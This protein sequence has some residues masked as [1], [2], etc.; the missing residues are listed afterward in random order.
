M[1]PL[2]A[3]GMGML[4]AFIIAEISLRL[5]VDP[6]AKRLAT[7]DATLGWKGRPNGD[8]LYVRKTDDIRVPFH[9]NNLGFRDEDVA[10]KPEHGRRIL[11]LGDSFIENL[12]VEY[13]KTFPFLLE[14][15]VKL[16]SREWDVAIVGSQGYSTAQQ[17][18]AFRSYHDAISPDVVLLCFYC[19]NDFEDN[20]RRRFAFLDEQGELC[21]PENNGSIWKHRARWLQRWLYESSHVVYLLKN[22]FQSLTNVRL[23]P[24]SKS[25]VDADE[26]YKLRI[27]AKL[28]QQ[29]A[30][31]AN[32]AGAEFGIVVIPFRDD[33]TSG[34]VQAQSFV[35]RLCEDRQIP[36]LDLSPVLSTD[37]YFKTDIHFNIKGHQIAAQAINEFLAT[38]FQTHP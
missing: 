21:I 32:A 25:I 33:L 19:G 28:L 11:I 10:A 38:S 4:C 7:Y 16:R 31:E 8:G 18:L 34:N 24:A 3:I 29:L 9:Y 6:E 2:I 30:Q 36:C 17:L 15:Q 14:Q 37:D 20:L 35:A 13:E 23:K 26:E 22:G 27:T 1:F 12:E 5:L